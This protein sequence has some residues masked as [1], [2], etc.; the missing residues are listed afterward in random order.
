MNDAGQF[1]PLLSNF[2]GASGPGR[3]TA[4]RSDPSA[5]KDPDGFE[6]I[7]D[8]AGGRSAD[9]ESG[10]ISTEES[11]PAKRGDDLVSD[12]QPFVIET[13]TA[14]HTRYAAVNEPLGIN[15]QFPGGLRTGLDDGFQYFR[16][17]IDVADV[18]KFATLPD[19]PLNGRLLT[20][21]AEGGDVR[22]SL[23]ATISTV[24]LAEATNNVP[25]APLNTVKLG[26]TATASGRISF[27]FGGLSQITTAPLELSPRAEGFSEVRSALSELGATAFRGATFAPTSAYAPAGASDAYNIFAASISGPPGGPSAAGEIDILA[28]LALATSA[29]ATRATG[30]PAIFAPS[31]THSFAGHAG[32]LPQIQ[33]AVIAGMG[34]DTVEVRLDPPDLGRVRIDFN[35]EGGDAIKAII[36]A[37]RSETLDHLRRNIADLE[38]QLRQAGF[39]S[40]SFEFRSG[41]DRHFSGDRDDSL[42]A[43]S[44]ESAAASDAPAKIYL[45]MRENA[46]LD[47]LL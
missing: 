13:P 28:D 21:N 37:D 29:G 45:S 32:V 35:V 16:A 47:L 25:D 18:S 15:L 3:S 17:K 2:A 27:D 1:G 33:A 14:H 6:K 24:K 42:S 9:T 8:Q 41:G 5:E 39:G 38:Q 7:F 12:Q 10:V 44:A 43:V 31:H 19:N 36:G 20:L 22:H 11:S 26:Q 46:Q 23:G 4:G 40:I 30:A 34:R